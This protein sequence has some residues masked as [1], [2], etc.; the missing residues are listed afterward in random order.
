MKTLDVDGFVETGATTLAFER[1]GKALMEKSGGR[2]AHNVPML[3]SRA[4]EDP[5]S[6][7]NLLFKH[8]MVLQCNHQR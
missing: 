2:L 5:Y 7:Y 3:E 1:W 4:G 8:K 6:C